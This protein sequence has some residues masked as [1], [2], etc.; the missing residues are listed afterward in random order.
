MM[1]P[2]RWGPPSP[3]G[4]GVTSPMWQDHHRQKQLRFP[5]PAPEKAQTI[6]VP[7]STTW[8]GS[9]RP[10]E[11]IRALHYFCN[12]GHVSQKGCSLCYNF[13]HLEKFLCP[14]QKRA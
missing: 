1:L 6:S 10:P 9:R 3:Q 4:N 12:E 5:P 11:L 8:T 14:P 13:P 7:T 2:R